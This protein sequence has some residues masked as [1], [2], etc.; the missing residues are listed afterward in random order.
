MNILS[1]IASIKSS[2][3]NRAFDLFQNLG[4]HILPVHFYSPIPD[5]RKIPER[6]WGLSRSGL[7]LVDKVDLSLLERMRGLSKRI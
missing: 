6:A 3:L 5:T 4:I 2:I 1:F 7:S